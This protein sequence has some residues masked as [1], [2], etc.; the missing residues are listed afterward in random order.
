MINDTVYTILIA[1]NK[2]Q[3]YGTAAGVIM[4]PSSD[5][6]DQWI[7]YTISDGLPDTRIWKLY[8][9]KNNRIWAIS[10]HGAA[11]YDGSSWKNLLTVSSMRPS[12]A[13]DAEGNMW[14]ASN[15]GLHRF[16]STWETFTTQNGLSDNF[17]NCVSVSGDGSIW[18]C[19]KNGATH[20]KD[21]KFT[22]YRAITQN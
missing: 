15:D 7:Y 13:E 8:E 19:T 20:I 12:F 9:D 3:W 1:K 11:Y 21:G 16:S 14:F 2:I 22:I 10:E 18:A 6:R 4:H 5:F 17:V